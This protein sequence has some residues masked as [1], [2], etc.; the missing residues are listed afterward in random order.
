[1]L[2]RFVVVGFLGGSTMSLLLFP[3]MYTMALRPTGSTKEL[4]LMGATVLWP[5]S[6]MLM[7]VQPT[8]STFF[9]VAVFAVTVVS[10]G[11][12]YGLGAICVWSVLRCFGLVGGR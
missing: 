11:V 5:T 10:N 7:A 9:S 4:L 8:S 6:P 3:V 2:T 1:V 12:L